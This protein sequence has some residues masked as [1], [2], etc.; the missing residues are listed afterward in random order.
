M[1]NKD[2]FSTITCLSTL[3]TYYNYTNHENSVLC[4]AKVFNKKLLIVH[5]SVIR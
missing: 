2:Q 1:K 3:Q 5:L 4:I